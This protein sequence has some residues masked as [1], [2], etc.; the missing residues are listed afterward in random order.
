[1][2]VYIKE[3]DLRLAALGVSKITSYLNRSG[4]YGLRVGM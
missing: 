2:P 4:Q 1:M 3:L